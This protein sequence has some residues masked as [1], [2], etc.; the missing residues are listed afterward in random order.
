LTLRASSYPRRDDADDKDDEKELAFHPSP[1]MVPKSPVT[2][3]DP[4]ED[5]A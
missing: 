5:D 1:P 2:Q 4:L 3:N